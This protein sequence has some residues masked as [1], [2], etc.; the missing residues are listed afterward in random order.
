MIKAPLKHAR[1]NGI[2]VHGHPCILECRKSLPSEVPQIRMESELL[3]SPTAR[4]ELAKI[5]D[6]VQWHDVGWNIDGELR[7]DL[8]DQ[9]MIEGAY[10]NLLLGMPLQHL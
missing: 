2:G 6:D 9:I 7:R 3:Q 10:P 1:W 8:L 5:G 4:G